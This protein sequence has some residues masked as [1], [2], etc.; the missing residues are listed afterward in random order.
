MLRMHKS[1]F[2]KIAV[3]LWEYKRRGLRA[4]LYL[5][6]K[7]E[8]LLLILQKHLKHSFLQILDQVFLHAIHDVDVHKYEILASAHHASFLPQVLLMCVAHRTASIATERRP[9]VRVAV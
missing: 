2:A 7:P 6:Q 1:T 9:K 5:K 3:Y 8:S 4:H